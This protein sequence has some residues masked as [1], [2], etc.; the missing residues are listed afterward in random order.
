MTSRL[1]HSRYQQVN[2]S[3]DQNIIY[4]LTNNIRSL[5]TIHE[6]NIKELQTENNSLKD[7]LKIV[8]DLY[9]GEKRKRIDSELNMEKHLKKC[10]KNKDESNCENK[11]NIV[12]YKK[13]KLSFSDEIIANIFANMKTIQDIIKLENQF[14]ETKH[15]EKLQKLSNII[16]PLKKLDQMI[17]LTQLKQDL[18]K[19]IIYYLQNQH[20]D[21]YLHT[22]INGPPGVGKTEFAKIYADIFL[23][24]GI[25]KSDKFTEIKRS[26][27]VAKYLGQ[28][29]HLTKE[30]FEK[31]M[32]GVI[33]LDEAYSL[34]NEDKRDSYSKEAIDTINQYLSE[35]KSDFMFIIA[36]YEDDLENCFFSVNK[37]LKRRFSHTFTISKYTH[38]ELASIFKLKIEKYGYSLSHASLADNK[39]HDFFKQ[40]YKKLENFAGDI[41]KLTNFVKYEHSYR[42]FLSQSSSNEITMSDLKT[43]IEKFEKIDHNPPPIG[44]Y[45]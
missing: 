3:F 38:Q 44:L 17:G 6:N 42:S 31:S 11:Y 40:H 19:I 22:I 1:R 14:E 35:R 21:E 39:Y 34:G 24:L 36:G 41:E 43:C 26:D 7:E 33:F 10:K 18:F 2:Y 5:T 45:I 37:G 8:N 29:S 27:L 16:P 32:G 12:I 30:L 20:T 9:S 13:T 28:T 23:R 4:L 15:N 25:L